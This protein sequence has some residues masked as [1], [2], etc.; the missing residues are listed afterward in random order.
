METGLK[1]K[2][3]LITGGN[4]GIGFGMAKA[5]AAEEVDLAVAAIVEVSGAMETLEEFGTKVVFL[6]VDVSKE[7]EA[8]SMVQRATGALGGLDLFVNNAVIALHQP[9]TQITSEAFYRTIDTNLAACLWAS[10]EVARH[11][12][13]QRSGSI[14]I[15]GSTVRVCPAYAEASYRISKMGLKMYMETLAIE[16]APFGIRVN[17]IMPGHHRTPLTSNIPPH[18]E[19]KVMA[20]I[21]LRRFGDP[22]GCGP[23]AVFLLS[24]LLSGYVT[25]TEIVVDG[26]LSLRPLP[27]RTDEEILQMNRP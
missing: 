13:S 24:D 9:V 27:L 23:A 15:T 20:E 11:M 22:D 18:I 19:A 12:I 6:K 14:L 4:S 16:L 7:S 25:G 21:P 8:V 2:K 17:M 3:C 1:G 10:R 26:G 5:L